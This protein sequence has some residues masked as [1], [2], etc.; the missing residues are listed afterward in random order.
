[1]TIALVT[2]ATGGLGPAIARALSADGATVYVHF[3]RNEAAATAL[4]AEL[5]GAEPIG[6][7]VRDSQAVQAAIRTITDAHG[8]LDL[9]VN[10]AGVVA[11]GPMAMLDDASLTDVIDTNLTG[12]FKV[13]RAAAR[14]MMGKRSGCIIN[15]SSVAGIRASPYQANYSAAKAGLLGLSRTMA[16]ELGSKGIRVNTVI[17]GLIRAGMGARVDQRHAD[18]VLERVPLGT[19]GEAEDVAAAVVFLASDGAR[20]ISG[21]ELTVDG[22]LCT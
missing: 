15:I 11:D 19:L 8:Q 18:A 10:N 9:L 17:P 16:R 4:C 22:G 3:R 12:T 2:G 21:A 20:Y 5:D 14:A 6:F 7:D 13:C 1:M